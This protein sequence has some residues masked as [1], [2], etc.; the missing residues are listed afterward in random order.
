[1]KVTIERGAQFDAASPGEV[2]DALQDHEA[3]K[4]RER[5]TGLKYLR[6]NPPVTGT[7]VAGLL[8][9][10]GDFQSSAGSTQPLGPRSG[11]AWAVMA[12][13]VTGLAA[14]DVVQVFRR[15]PNSQPIWTLTAA[16]PAAVFSKGQ[17][18]L[19]DG[20]SLMVQNFGAF[21]SVAEITLGADV[22]EVPQPLLWKLIL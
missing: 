19:L 10:G 18:I 5:A 3:A 21:T 9:M 22:Y 1:M 14:G 2:R 15:G 4:L 6:L 7:A 20:E 13:R 8:Q 17:Q 11:Y 12:L 16:V